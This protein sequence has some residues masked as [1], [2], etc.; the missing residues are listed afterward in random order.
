MERR[1]IDPAKLAAQYKTR[2]LNYLAGSYGVDKGTI[3]RAL[4]AAG[5]TLR[6]FPAAMRLAHARKTPET[7]RRGALASSRANLGKR[8]S[9]ETMLRR[10]KAAEGRPWHPYEVKL[11]ELLRAGGLNV[12]IRQA[13]G[14]YNA[15][16]AVRPVVIEPLCSVAALGGDKLARRMRRIA[17]FLG[18]GWSVLA[19][20]GIEE[21]DVEVAAW[22]KS[23]CALMSHGT[24][25]WALVVSRIPR[26]LIDFG[27]DPEE[28]RAA[29]G[30]VRKGMRKKT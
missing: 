13:I 18:E 6:D 23:H 19:V 17:H 24:P 27:T 8:M 14:P 28:L 1:P 10:A 9:A 25:E 26:A 11:A 16:L 3:Q 4:W 21:P 5:A 15:P 7:R 22:V 12:T 29:I 2:S 20:V 30:R